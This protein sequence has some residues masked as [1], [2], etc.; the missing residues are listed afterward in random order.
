[1]LYCTKSLGSSSTLNIGQWQQA[2]ALLQQA[3]EIRRTV[4]DRAG[5]AQIMQYMAAEYSHTG[6]PQRAATL[7]EA[8]IGLKFPY[9]GGDE[10]ERLPDAYVRQI[11][12]KTIAVMTG[13]DDSFDEWRKTI[14][15]EHEQARQQKD[16]GMRE[17]DFFSAILSSLDGKATAISTENP[18][19]YA[20]EAIQEGIAVNRQQAFG[21]S[22]MMIKAVSDFV[23]AR[24]GDET[25]EVVEVW[26]DLLFRPEI[27]ALFEENIAQAQ[28]SKDERTA[29]VLELHLSILHECKT[30]GI[31]STFERIK[32]AQQAAE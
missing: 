10:H 20:I 7:M 18:Y 29:R 23:N 1:L 9:M 27:E 5:A 30:R 32:A 12:T 4:G 22:D 15:Q 28:A 17:L 11:I 3:L 13:A 8:L 31:A 25:Q 26:Q 16:S 21:V 14:E 6:Q 19:A 2:L 24:D